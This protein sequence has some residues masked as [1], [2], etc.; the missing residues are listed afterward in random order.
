MS[1]AVHFGAGNI[2]RGFLGQ[3]YWQSGWETVFVDVVD[4]VVDTLN[5]R[6]SYNIHIVD[7]HPEVLTIERV[8]AVHGSDREAVA[9]AVAACD[10][11][12]VAVGVGALI[13]VAPA[14]AAGIARRADTA[15]APLDIVVCENLLNA[16][17]TL[18]GLI[19]DKLES[20]AQRAFVRDRVG[21]VG[22]VVSRMVPVVPEAKR[23]ED[24]LYVAV[25]V[26]DDTP[27]L[28]GFDPRFE[29]L[30]CHRGDSLFLRFQT[31]GVVNF[32]TYYWSTEQKVAAVR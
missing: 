5:A 13:H 11:A 21:F 28:N 16:A 32:F 15:G 9:E 14:L 7:E 24:P 25:E 23:A 6:G 1:T 29:P 26:R 19:L 18:R 10:L 17:D 31:G 30:I 2:G 3:L 27:L 8:R 22:T 12:S 20:E 4:A